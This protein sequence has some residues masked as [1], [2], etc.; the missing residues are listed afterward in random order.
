MG[1]VV[2]ARPRRWR[3]WP[4]T[5]SAL[6]LG[7]DLGG[8][9]RRLVGPGDDLVVDV[10]DV[11]H[12]ASPRRRTTAGSAA[13]RR[14][15]ARSGRARG[16][17]ARRRWARTRTSR[18]RPGSRGSRGTTAPRAVSNRSSTTVT[19]L[20]PS[21]PQEGLRGRRETGGSLGGPHERLCPPRPATPGPFPRSRTSTAW[22]TAGAGVGG[23]T[24]PTASTAPP[25]AT[26]STRS[27]RRHPRSAGRCTWATCSPTPTPTPSP[28]TSACG[29][30]DV[31][32]PM[33]WDDNGLP[34]ERRV[35]NYYG[36][37][38]DPSLPYDPS[39][40]APPRSRSAPRPSARPPRCRSAG[41]TS[42]SCATTSPPRTKTRSRSCGATS[43][44]PSTG[45]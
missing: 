42:S 23:T 16:G 45:R 22:R 24:A 5:R 13:G 39:F 7:H 1:V 31:F 14:T 26:R 8:G 2:G 35:Q 18:S 25:S 4:P 44:S 6:V 36:V 38:C 40:A 37:R 15:P 34:T 27:T 28:A 9:A 33:G 41:A 32:Y 20:R 3:P 12:V 10:G 43:A 11:R 19:L 30:S 17:A 29:A 21:R